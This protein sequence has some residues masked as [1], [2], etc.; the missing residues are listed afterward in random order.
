MSK[1]GFD[2]SK[3]EDFILITMELTSGR[4]KSK[5]KLPLEAPYENIEAALG[6]WW[7]TLESVVKCRKTELDAEVK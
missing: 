7:Q 6:N 1:T 5:I 3:E 2:Q 4:F